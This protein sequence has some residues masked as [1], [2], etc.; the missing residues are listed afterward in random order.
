MI[1]EL[2][3][4]K[5]PK[6]RLAQRLPERFHSTPDEAASLYL[7][8][9]YISHEF[10]HVVFR[11]SLLGRHATMRGTRLMVWELVQLT[12]A[13]DGDALAVAAHLEIDASLVEEALRF[14]ERYSDAV[15]AVIQRSESSTL[16]QMKS[17]FPN[18]E[19]F[20]SRTEGEH[21]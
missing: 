21:E 16:E 13:F 1:T 20:E 17:A 15:E 2:I 5:E 7:D 4:I 6:T 18:L 10:P 12:R 14:A 9:L 19:I 8:D 3:E 11:R